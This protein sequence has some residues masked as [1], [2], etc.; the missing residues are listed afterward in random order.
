MKKVDDK[1]IGLDNYS[2]ETDEE[3]LHRMKMFQEAGRTRLD[4]PIDVF[5]DHFE[6]SMR[7][8]KLL[9]K[10]KRLLRQGASPKILVQIDTEIDKEV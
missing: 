6:K 8:E 9:K 1:K 2:V 10:I 4:F 7:M 3:I 5:I